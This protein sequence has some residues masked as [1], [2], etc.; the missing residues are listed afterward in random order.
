MLSL[1]TC[2]TGNVSFEALKVAFVFFSA[3][4]FDQGKLCILK[5]KVTSACQKLH[6][7]IM[8]DSEILCILVLSSQHTYAETAFYVNKILS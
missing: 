4:Q 2:K 5:W 8:P 7:K 3:Q 6:G 1:T